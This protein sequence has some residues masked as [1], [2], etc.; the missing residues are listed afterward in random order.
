MNKEN[1]IDGTNSMIDTAKDTAWK[2]LL[3]K[4]QQAFWDSDCL[5]TYTIY[6]GKVKV[7]TDDSLMYYL[8]KWTALKDRVYDCNMNDRTHSWLRGQCQATIN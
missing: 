5:L 3:V 7:V 8:S 2:I 6:T 1:A 4:K